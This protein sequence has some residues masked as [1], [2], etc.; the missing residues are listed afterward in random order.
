MKTPLLI[1]SAVFSVLLIV[2]LT[3]SIFPELPKKLFSSDKCNL[4]SYSSAQEYRQAALDVEYGGDSKCAIELWKK[5]V[6]KRATDVSALSN[7]AM[8]LT[9]AEQYQESLN[10]YERSIKLGGGASDTFAWYARSLRQLNRMPLAI[11]WYY[12][13]LSIDPEL[14]DITMEL[15]EL[16]A[17]QNQHYEA[18]AVLAG[19]E[20][21]TG[22]EGYFDTR[23]ISLQAT[24]DNIPSSDEKKSFRVPKLHGNHFYI[25]VRVSDSRKHKPK[26]FIV[27]T[28]ASILTMDKKWL[29]DND[30]KYRVIKSR[31]R[32]MVADGKI[33]RA[34]KVKIP[35]LKLGAFELHDVKAVICKYCQPLIGQNILKRFDL[36]TQ[37]VNG[38]EFLYLKERSK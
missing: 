29:D 27:D 22:K 37:R 36:N 1:A 24:L 14:P 20:E 25:S 26:A 10:Y 38:V 4:S 16:L 11:A 28:G 3:F 9:Q 21:A 34:K 13:T 32:M 18:I 19:F 6:E 17:L 35:Y 2:T 8:R 33:I 30:V 23:K 12:R 15:S 31:V 5:V 7:L